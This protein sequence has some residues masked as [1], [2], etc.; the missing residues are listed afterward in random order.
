VTGGPPI[1]EAIILA[2]PGDALRPVVRV[3]LLVRTVLALERAGVERC[4]V[5]GDVPTPADPRIR[6]RLATAPVLTPA[7]DDALRIVVGAGAVI[8]AALV[9]DLQARARPGSVLEVEEDGVRVRVAPGPLV[10]GNGGAAVRPRKGTLRRAGSP[11]VERALLRALENPRD[12]YL[13]RLL[14]RRLSRPVTR[15]LLRTP[16]TPNAVTAVGIALG[17]AGGA[18]L[19]LPGPAAVAAAVALL[20]ASGVLDCSDG[21]IERIRFGE[22]RLGHWLDV[23]GDTAVHLALLGGIATRIARSG[24]APGWSLLGVLLL[25]ILGA[26]ATITWSEETEARRHRVPGW[27]NR[28]LDGVLSPLTTRDWHVFPV[29]L[30]LVGRLDLL[31][32]AGAIGAH[33]FWVVAL[34]LLRRVLRR[35]PP[36]R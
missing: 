8:D 35:S 22:S 23:S 2:G 17:V 27:E 13:D 26:F 10:A 34:V 6:C 9:R 30:A 11:D 32:P 36:G 19:G 18:A 12:G 16:V 31:V 29:L 14:H 25:G 28:L 24:D 21:E 7:R 4:T 33:A 15:V 5:V 3:P 1:R 20:V